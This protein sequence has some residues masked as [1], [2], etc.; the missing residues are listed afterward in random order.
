[1]AQTLSTTLRDGEWVAVTV[2]K[3]FAWTERRWHQRW[4]HARAQTHHSL[5]PAAVV[6]TVTA[7]GADRESAENAAQQTVLAMPG[8][9]YPV[10]VRRE[11]GARVAA[12]LGVPGGMVAALALGAGQVGF[13]A[14]LVVPLAVVAATLLGAAVAAGAGWLP[15]GGAFRAR[16][17]RRGRFGAPILRAGLVPKR[18]QGSHTIVGQDGTVARVPEHP[19]DYPI[20]RTAFVLG[21]LQAIALAAPHSGAASGA[22]QSKVRV[23]P[24][25]L[26]DRV[27][28]SFGVSF[29]ESCYLSER[30]RYSGM[31]L[32]GGPGSGKSQYLLTV[33][34]FD[35]CARARQEGPAGGNAMVWFDTKM[36]GEAAASAARLSKDAGDRFVVVSVGDPT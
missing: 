25:S 8:W 17:I 33:W 15:L 32:S 14:S 30:D 19:G 13:L 31:F 16:M 12:A 11:S 22:G 18:P 21:P 20:S 36:D 23:A 6:A 5:D 3:P 29:G 34:G 9:D 24:P 35:A 10:R 1:M 26:R 28:P 4:M 27:G 7:G 2:R